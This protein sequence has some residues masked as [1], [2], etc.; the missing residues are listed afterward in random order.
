MGHASGRAARVSAIRPRQSANVLR[1]AATRF[2]SFE[3]DRFPLFCV[4]LTVSVVVT[5]VVTESEEDSEEAES[6]SSYEV[7]DILSGRGK[8]CPLCDSSVYSYCSDKLL[9]DACCCLSPY[10]TELPY[11]CKFADCGFLHANSCNEHHLITSC[12]CNQAAST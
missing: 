8:H 5:A 6:H 3:M 11:Q 4:F 1:S 10:D 2:A 9:H 12:C 7:E